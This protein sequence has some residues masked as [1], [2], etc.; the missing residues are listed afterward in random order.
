MSILF[1]K[2]TYLF[3]FGLFNKSSQY[4]AS[5]DTFIDVTARESNPVSFKNVSY[6]A[7]PSVKKGGV[8]CVIYT[9]L[10]Q[11]FL[12]PGK[13]IIWRASSQAKPPSTFL[14]AFSFCISCWLENYGA[15]HALG[16]KKG[17]SIFLVF[18]SLFFVS[19]SK[20]KSLKFYPYYADNEYSLIFR[21][22]K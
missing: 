14:D 6:Y 9:G 5:A 13:G 20:I 2:I 7:A 22:S 15:T 11:F 3:F 17:K 1:I 18:Y 12:A 16:E 19:H 4:W 10:Y 8:I 21:P